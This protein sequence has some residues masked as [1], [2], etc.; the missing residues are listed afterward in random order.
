[1]RVARLLAVVL[2]GSIVFSSKFAAAYEYIPPSGGGGGG[3]PALGFCIIGAAWGPI[4]A[5]LRLNRELKP[6][7]AYQTMSLC[8]LG[9]GWLVFQNQRP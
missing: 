7:E 9:A 6:N 4:W 3:T 1:M 5:T 8:G 2:A